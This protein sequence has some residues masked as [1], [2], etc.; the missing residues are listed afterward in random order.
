M[1]KMKEKMK[2]YTDMY[3]SGSREIYRVWKFDFFPRHAHL[4]I[5]AELQNFL[6]CNFLC[7]V[8]L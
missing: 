2:G 1:Q 4:F 5:T 7:L 3:L 8:H 6:L